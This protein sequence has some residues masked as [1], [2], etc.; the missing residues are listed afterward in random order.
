MANHNKEE[1]LQF[2]SSTHIVDDSYLE[3]DKKN[4]PESDIQA[5]VQ[6]KKYMEAKHIMAKQLILNE[7]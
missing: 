1:Y 6:N 7:E 4:K 3:L 5:Q 2:N